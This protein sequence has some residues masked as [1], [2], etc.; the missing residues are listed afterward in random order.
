MYVGKNVSFKL[1]DVSF[2]NTCLAI[3]IRYSKLKAYNNIVYKPRQLTKKT[4]KI[5]VALISDQ[6]FKF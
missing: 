1:N 4:K 3:S 2:Q 6:N 5:L